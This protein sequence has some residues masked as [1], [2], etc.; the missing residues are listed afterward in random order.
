MVPAGRHPDAERAIAE[1]FVFPT[2]AFFAMSEQIQGFSFLLHLSWN[3]GQLTFDAAKGLSSGIRFTAHSGTLVGSFAGTF[4]KAHSVPSLVA[5]L[6]KLRLTCAC[7]G[8]AHQAT[9][10]PDCVATFLSFS[11]PLDWVG[12]QLFGNAVA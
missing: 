1:K 9:L 4:C 11:D 7:R 12:R 10:T 5:R 6:H 8:T 2:A 3:E